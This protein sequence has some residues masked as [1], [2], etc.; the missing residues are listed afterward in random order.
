MGLEPSITSMARPTIFT[1]D[2]LQKLEDAFSMG[3]TDEEA[4]VL[5]NI[6]PSSLYNYQKSKPEFLERKQLLHHR[7]ILKA[8]HTIINS[9][10]DPVYAFKYLER[11]RRQEFGPG[12]RVDLVEKPKEIPLTK[13]QIE[14]IERLAGMG[15]TESSMEPQEKFPPP[16]L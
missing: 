6:A 2:V 1:K 12:V 11:K 10:G 13:E 4:C 7:P 5:A 3:C 9:L 15:R 14:K 16:L 8:R